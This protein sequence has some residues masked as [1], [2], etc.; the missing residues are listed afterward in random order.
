VHN[1]IV[2]T[3]KE[4]GAVMDKHSVIGIDLAKRSIQVCLVNTRSN[5]GMKLIICMSVL[6]SLPSGRGAGE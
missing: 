6:L 2:E 3:I 4:L 5:K 1:G